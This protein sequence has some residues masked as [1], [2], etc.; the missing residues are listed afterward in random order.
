MEALAC[1]KCG[2]TMQAEKHLQALGSE[3][4]L[5]SK[6]AFRFFPEAVRSERLAANCKRLKARARHFLM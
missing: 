3:V 4:V 6:S 5:V 1:P 2:S